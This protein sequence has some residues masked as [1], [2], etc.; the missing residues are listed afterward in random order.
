[1]PLFPAR[2]DFP[3]LRGKAGLRTDCSA[4]LGV[5]VGVGEKPTT[6]L[7][8]EERVMDGNG[9]WRPESITA[10]LYRWGFPNNALPLE[11]PC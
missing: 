11:T 9:P 7:P 2:D 8:G 5:G 1:M 4:R 10:T 3:G 6:F